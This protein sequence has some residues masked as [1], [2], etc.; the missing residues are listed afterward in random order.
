MMTVFQALG[1]MFLGGFI[2]EVFEIRAW[3]RYHQGKREAQDFPPN[4]QNRR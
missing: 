4:F 2:V 1:F 3:A